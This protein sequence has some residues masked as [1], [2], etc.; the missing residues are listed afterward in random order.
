MYPAQSSGGLFLWLKK[1]KEV[2]FCFLATAGMF[3]L[4]SLFVLSEMGPVAGLSSKSSLPWRDRLQFIETT[5]WLIR[6]LVAPIN[7][8][9]SGIL[10]L[11]VA[12]RC[13]KTYMHVCVF[14]CIVCGYF[15]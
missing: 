1:K 14:V 7:S 13:R 8:K 10:K 6:S 9:Q 2:L 3:I 12:S 11:F 5:C 4:L 15:W